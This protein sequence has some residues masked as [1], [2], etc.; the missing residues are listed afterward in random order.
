MCRCPAPADC[1]CLLGFELL[2]VP[3]C[4]TCSIPRPPQPVLAM[5]KTTFPAGKRKRRAARL[6]RYPVQS[7]ERR[8]STLTICQELPCRSHKPV[9]RATGTRL[10]RPY[11]LLLEQHFSGAIPRC[12]GRL[13]RIE[14]PAD[15]EERRPLRRQVC[16]VALGRQLAAH[17]RSVA[18]LPPGD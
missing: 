18:A 17:G 10:T 3:C 5:P 11:A 12:L 2:T 8:S 14:N 1:R 7:S 13:M 16:S 15:S 6:Q 9:R 4:L